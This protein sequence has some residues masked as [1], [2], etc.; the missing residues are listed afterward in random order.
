M[1]FAQDVA[2]DLEKLH[3][4]IEGTAQ[5]TEQHYH[6]QV[7]QLK[8]ELENSLQQCSDTIASISAESAMPEEFVRRFNLSS[9]TTT[10]A[11]A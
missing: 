2:A 7:A 11:S 4:L 5:D 9:T 1:E 10:T 6:D 8:S 3:Q